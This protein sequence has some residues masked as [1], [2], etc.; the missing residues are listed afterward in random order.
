MKKFI[1]AALGVALGVVG[2]NAYA[3]TAT[4]SLTP[5][6]TLTGDCT[7]AVTNTAFTTL[8][9]TSAPS[10]AITQSIGGV[11]I[12]GCGTAAYKLGANAGGAS[13]TGGSRYL[14]VADANLGATAD[15]PY[16]LDLYK[17]AVSQVTNWGDAGMTTVTTTGLN[18]YVKAADVSDVSATADVFDIKGIFTLPAVGSRVAGTYIDTVTVTVEF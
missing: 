10:T 2:V 18:A 9:K 17:G 12:A 14:S 8:S 4:G 5:S 7:I 11:T 16:S 13:F 3:A 15:I 1:I 6:L